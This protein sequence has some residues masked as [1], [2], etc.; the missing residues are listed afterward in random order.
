LGVRVAESCGESLQNGATDQF[1]D[2]RDYGVPEPV[3]SV[4]LI[5]YP[6]SHSRKLGFT[7]PRSAFRPCDCRPD[8]RLAVGVGHNVKPRPEVWGA[9]GESRKH[10]PLRIIPECIEAA[11][12]DVQ[13]ESAKTSGVFE[14]DEPRAE[15]ADEP[16]NV[17]PQSG[18]LSGKPDRSLLG[19]AKVLAREAG[20]KDIDGNSIGS[21]LLSG[22]GSQVMIDWH[23]G[24]MLRQ[25][26]A[27]E[28]FDLAEGH[29][30][31]STRALKAQR[32]SSDAATSVEDPQALGFGG[33][34]HDGRRTARTGEFPGH[35][36]I[37]NE[38][39]LSPRTHG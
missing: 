24:P 14:D 16:L 6:M 3:T 8:R 9:N 32:K 36:I 7:G 30:P 1:R 33:S 35:A 39:S 19:L 11:E 26:S 5:G 37:L 27:R 4:W 25:H 31:K 23:S 29:G 22:E 18:P 17:K 2:G 38:C 28:L 21:K 20:G 15:A 13:S 12:D 34:P 10:M